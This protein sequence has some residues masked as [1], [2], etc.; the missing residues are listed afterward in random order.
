MIKADGTEKFK[1]EFRDVLL[2]ADP[3]RVV[4][5]FADLGLSDQEIARYFRVDASV[6]RKYF[7]TLELSE[8][9]LG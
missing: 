2:G 9:S 7:S 8:D 5:T 1:R 4:A 3:Y 6:I